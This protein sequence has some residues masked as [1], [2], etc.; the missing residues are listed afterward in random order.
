[1]HFLWL[2][3][4]TERSKLLCFSEE[5]AENT[6]NMLSDGL[7]M[8]RFL[9]ELKSDAIVCGTHIYHTDI[10]VGGGGGHVLLSQRIGV[11]V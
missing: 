11:M 10:C 2:I 7:Q 4:S 5:K 1:M 3:V 9:K 6:R 8:I